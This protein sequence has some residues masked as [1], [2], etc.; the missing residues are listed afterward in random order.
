VSSLHAYFGSGSQL[1]PLGLALEGSNWYAVY[2]ISRHEKRVA[3]QFEEK[4][5]CTFLPLL[6]Q[7]HK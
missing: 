7:I 4:G 1:V 5:V 2:T 6:R 3:A